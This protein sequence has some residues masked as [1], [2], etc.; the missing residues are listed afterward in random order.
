M[1]KFL[2]VAACA[3]IGTSVFAFAGC[4]GKDGGSDFAVGGD[5][6]EA[7][8]EDINNIMSSG[9]SFGDASAADYMLGL[10]FK[11]DL[12]VSYKMGSMIDASGNFALNYLFNQTATEIKGAGEANAKYTATY[13]EQKL[14]GKYGVKAYNDGEK[15]YASVSGLESLGVAGGVASGYVSYWNII[16]EIADL[17]PMTLSAV[18]ADTAELDLITLATQYKVGVYVDNSNGL[19]VKI[20]VTKDTV[21]ALLD[22][23]VE[24]EAAVTAIK[25]N[26]TVNKFVLDAYLVADATNVFKQ[27]ALDVNI[28]VEAKAADTGDTQT[29][30]VSLKVKGGVSV[31]MTGSVV[32]LSGLN[33]ADYTVDY[34]DA[35]LGLIG[36]IGH[37]QPGPDIEVNPVD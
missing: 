17:V 8:A 18:S 4:G 3:A 16:N 12:D 14:E 37:E 1:K 34:T 29:G 19:K 13:G 33:K 23:F 36:G 31:N 20:S 6:K 25:E 27:L 10:E 5:Y 26:L 11:A 32:D 9:V 28:D 2:A 15:A 35:V 24:E 22:A 7:T 21:F 30:D